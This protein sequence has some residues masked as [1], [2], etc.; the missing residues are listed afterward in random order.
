MLEA[1]KIEINRTETPKAEV[2]K[3][4]VTKPEE[5]KTEITISETT[6]TEVIKSE[7][8]LT[9]ISTRLDE[10]A[11]L[12]IVKTGESNPEETAKS[13]DIVESEIK[14]ESVE[15]QKAEEKNESNEE[16]VTSKKC[17]S[18]ISI[19]VSDEN[20]KD[21]N[22]V[23]EKDKEILPEKTPEPMEVDQEEENTKSTTNEDVS[24]EV[25]ISSDIEMEQ[26]SD[27]SSEIINQ[28]NDQEKPKSIVTDYQ[29]TETQE[30]LK[31]KT[32]E[33]N[34]ENFINS[35][36]VE[37]KIESINI[38]INNASCDINSDTTS[39][40]NMKV[41]ELIVKSKECTTSAESVDRLKAMFPELEV[42]HKDISSP[43]IDK[44]PSH[45][46]LQQIDQTIAHLLATSYQNPIKWPKV[47]YLLF[48]FVYICVV[49][50]W[51]QV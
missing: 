2:N 34:I 18:T 28:Q 35:D 31:D 4:E 43:V 19:V 27:K 36:D 17:E 12:E 29:Q 24:K 41:T 23:V 46:P 48:Y 5:A 26:L 13:E 6:V 42:V 25:V 50:V 9:E 8:V 16:P 32:H 40:P 51:N 37:A 11:K 44:L 22:S 33:N 10:S 20:E 21:K 47:N 38:E 3:I 15:S 39:K 7:A 1:A 45:K 49:N 14:L 30:K